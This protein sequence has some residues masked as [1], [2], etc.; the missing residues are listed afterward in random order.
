MNNTAALA[1]LSLLAIEP[2]CMNRRAPLPV[3]PVPGN[4]QTLRA[5]T[6]LAL[7]TASAI[8]SSVSQPGQTF[9][10]VVSRDANDA[11]GQLVLP[12]GSPVTLILMRV[13]SALPKGGA[14]ELRI[15]SVTLNGDSYLVR[16]ESEAGNAAVPGA[17]VGTFLGGVAGTQNI[18]SSGQN[19]PKGRQITV[20]GERIWAPVGS[21]LTFRLEMPVR[22]IGSH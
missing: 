21:L 1:L 17:S 13:A 6:T 14:L 5:G 22:L 12:S 10:C 4:P 11:E 18:P 15:A 9:P 16:N 3:V 8:D 7:R 20:T 19:A 2:G